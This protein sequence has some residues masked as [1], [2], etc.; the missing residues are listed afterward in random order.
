MTFL[1]FF[2]LGAA[3]SGYMMAANTMI[4]EFGSR[5][6]MPM[7]IAISATAE[8]IMAAIGPLAGGIMASTLGFPVVFGVSIGFLVAALLLLIV[9]VKEP[10]TAR[11]GRI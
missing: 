8:G 1:A 7:R 10:R 5:D 6:E 9:A 11:L 2:G 4:L 3:Q